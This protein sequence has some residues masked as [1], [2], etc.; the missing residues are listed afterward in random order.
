[1]A[2]Q[3]GDAGLAAR[4]AAEKP[5]GGRWHETLLG[6]RLLWQD[7]ALRSLTIAIMVLAAVYLPAETVV[8]PAYFEALSAPAGLGIVLSALAAGSVIGAF[9]Y[10]WISTRMTRYHLAR[11]TLVGTVVTIIPMALLPPLPLMTAAG[12]CLGLVWGPM[13]PLMSTLVQRRIPADVQGRVYGVQLSVFYAAPPLAMLVAGWGIER[14]GVQVTYLVLAG[15]LV[16][17]ALSVLF[18]RSIRDIDD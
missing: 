3:V 2:L 18:V 6:A 4:R 1:V 17:T 14:F 16:V 8:L 15:A 12:F 9:G 10:G 13:N 5:T 11:L 7:K